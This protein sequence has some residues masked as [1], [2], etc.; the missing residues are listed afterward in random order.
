MKAMATVVGSDP[1]AVRDAWTTFARGVQRDAETLWLVATAPSTSASVSTA[2]MPA[3][4]EATPLQSLLE[5]PSNASLARMLLHEGLVVSLV[6]ELDVLQD[7]SDALERRLSEREGDHSH[8][9]EFSSFKDDASSDRTSGFEQRS[10]SR[11]TS[12]DSAAVDV[13][14]AAAAPQLLPSARISS[15]IALEASNATPTHTPPRG[16]ARTT[17]GPYSDVNGTLAR[18]A[19]ALDA[20]RSDVA[21]SAALAPSEAVGQAASVS[22]AQDLLHITAMLTSLVSE[23]RVDVQIATADANRASRD[24]DILALLD[25]PVGQGSAR[26]AKGDLDE[27]IDATRTRFTQR[28]ESIAADV[29]TVRGL[30]RTVAAQIEEQQEGTPRPRRT[31]SQLPSSPS[32]FKALWS[33]LPAIA[34]SPGNPPKVGTLVGDSMALAHS[35]PPQRQQTSTMGTLFSDSVALAHSSPPRRQQMSTTSSS[36][37]IQSSAGD[38]AVDT[39]AELQLL[40]LPTW[41]DLLTEKRGASTRQREGQGHPRRTLRAARSSPTLGRVGSVGPL[42]EAQT[43]VAGSSILGLA[44]GPARRGATKLVGTPSP[45]RTWTS[46][47][48]RAGSSLSTLASLSSVGVD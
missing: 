18:L 37:D 20:L 4:E 13:S 17:G 42:W 28:T 27:V 33:A 25:S 31:T 19:L 1:L 43:S 9:D 39:L 24:Q 32:P 23:L 46:L 10:R 40:S 16:L 30:A 44:A 38:H 34:A 36:P 11:R 22:P 35:S 2:V 26:T 41:R 5:D 3:T 12:L 15:P 48:Q 14:H 47:R 8:S 21:F 7:R 45:R 29:D 6:E